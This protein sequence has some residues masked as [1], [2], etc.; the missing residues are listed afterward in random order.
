MT[1][2]ATL[3]AR[4]TEAETALH[5]LMTGQMEVSVAFEGQQVRYTKTDVGMLK[6]YIIDL[7]SDIVAAGGTDSGSVRAPV[8]LPQ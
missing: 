7:R 5:A 8:V 1:D 6:A 2:L 3:Q 4:L